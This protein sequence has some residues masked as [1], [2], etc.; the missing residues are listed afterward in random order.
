MWPRI[1]AVIVFLYLLCDSCSSEESIIGTEGRV[2]SLSILGWWL[3]AGCGA[4]DASLEALA[5]HHLSL[6]I[7]DANL[8][9]LLRILITFLSTG[10]NMDKVGL[11]AALHLLVHLI[12]IIAQLLTSANDPTI[13]IAW[14]ISSI[15]SEIVVVYDLV[16]EGVLVTPSLL[17]REL[18]GQVIVQV[19]IIIIVCSILNYDGRPRLATAAIWCIQRISSV[20][21]QHSLVEW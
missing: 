21:T 15:S 13:A 17:H 12:W 11:A 6:Q 3:L 1:V 7:F 2:G 10:I 20:C 16:W 9:S 5:R 4:A 8:S 19:S 18:L 14:A